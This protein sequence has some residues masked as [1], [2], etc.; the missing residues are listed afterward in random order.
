MNYPLVRW[1]ILTGLALLSSSL[2]KLEPQW[3]ATLVHH[4]PFLNPDL[5]RRMASSSRLPSPDS[6]FLTS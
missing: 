6:F 4:S 3:C 5:V 2:A 1:R